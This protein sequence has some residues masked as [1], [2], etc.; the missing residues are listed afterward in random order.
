M[1]DE[2]FGDEYNNSDVTMSIMAVTA[3]H[4]LTSDNDRGK[5]I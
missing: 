5:Y 2:Y 4:K 3:S 1:R